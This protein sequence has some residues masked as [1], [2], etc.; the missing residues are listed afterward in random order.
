ME[1]AGVFEIYSAE[2]ALA[3]DCEIVHAVFVPLHRY[4]LLM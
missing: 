4:R 2:I 3:A 1:P